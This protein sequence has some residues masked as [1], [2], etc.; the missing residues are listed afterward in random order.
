MKVHSLLLYGTYTSFDPFHASK[1][2][3]LAKCP[4]SVLLT[5]LPGYFLSLG[6]QFRKLS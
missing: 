1:I 6:L 4:N 2:Q 5:K 3:S